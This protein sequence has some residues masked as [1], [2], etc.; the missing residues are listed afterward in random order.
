[1][2]ELNLKTAFKTHTDIKDALQAER[3]ILFFT[4][5]EA[6]LCDIRAFCKRFRSLTGNATAVDKLKKALKHFLFTGDGCQ[7]V[8][9]AIR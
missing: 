4:V 2:F 1:M 5:R 9:V 8:W 7:G 6:T 3:C